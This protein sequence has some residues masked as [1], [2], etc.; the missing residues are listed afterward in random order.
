[1]HPI[2]NCIGCAQ[3]DDHPRHVMA[4]GDA[5]VNWHMDCHVIATGCEVCTAQL[6]D[7]GGIEGNPKGQQLR[8]HLVTTGPTADKPGWTAPG[9]DEIAEG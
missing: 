1:M 8:D 4:V 2:R 9:L 5:D 3:S 7:V 6:A